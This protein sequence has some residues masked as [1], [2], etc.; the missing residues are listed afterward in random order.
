[1]HAGAIATALWSGVQRLVAAFSR[2]LT[3]AFGT[4]GRVAWL[5]CNVWIVALPFLVLYWTAYLERVG[6]YPS[7]GPTMPPGYSFGYITLISVFVVAVIKDALEEVASKAKLINLFESIFFVGSAMLGIIGAYS[8]LFQRYGLLEDKDRVTEPL[9]YIY[10]S[11]VTWTTLGYG[12]IKP[13]QDCRI[14]AASEALY[15][16]AA[17]ALYLT[18]IFHVMSQYQPRGS[19]G[20]SPK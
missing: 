6:N 8:V 5:V 16:Y 13:T 14:V 18:L 1:M 10:F 2:P 11:V 4:F 7:P 19:T 3:V 9:D 20:Q 17:M 15:G 12:D